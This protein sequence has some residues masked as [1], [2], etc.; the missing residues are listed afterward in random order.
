[1]RHADINDEHP[2]ADRYCP[3]G[4]RWASPTPCWGCL[5]EHDE[6]MRRIAK[7]SPLAAD[8]GDSPAGASAPAGFLGGSD[9]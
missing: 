6:A 2:P 3:H 5:A 4:I 8:G 9:E 1:M 7:E